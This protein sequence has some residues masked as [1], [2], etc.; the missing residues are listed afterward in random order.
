MKHK[1]KTRYDVTQIVYVASI[2]HLLVGISILTNVDAKFNANRA[3][4]APGGNILF[5]YIEK[6]NDANMMTSLI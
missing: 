4:T 6:A 5:F 2:H 3:K 1:L